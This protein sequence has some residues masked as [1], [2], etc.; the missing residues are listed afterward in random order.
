MIYAKTNGQ[1]IANELESRNELQ[2]G[3]KTA[4]GRLSPF[5]IIL[6]VSD[7]IWQNDSILIINFQDIITRKSLALQ[8]KPLS[9]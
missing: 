5:Y 3:R 4:F 7:K 9:K 8:I 1:S 2:K 6:L